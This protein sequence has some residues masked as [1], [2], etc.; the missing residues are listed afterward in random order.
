MTTDDPSWTPPTGPAAADPDATDDAELPE[1]PSGDVLDAP[2]TGPP[3]VDEALPP[4]SLHTVAETPSPP[5]PPTEPPAAVTPIDGDPPTI[6]QPWAV[7]AHTAAG[8]SGLAIE[9]DGREHDVVMR[10]DATA[11]GAPAT[12]T[13]TIDDVGAEPIRYR[14]AWRSSWTGGVTDWHTATAHPVEG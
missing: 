11:D 9:V 5:A 8:V 14:F 13:A 1:G 4:P 12:W 7:R 6:G 2:P 10:R 3:I